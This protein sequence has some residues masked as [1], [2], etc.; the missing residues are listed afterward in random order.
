MDKDS[1]RSLVK[2]AVSFSILQ[3]IPSGPEALEVFRLFKISSISAC[4]MFTDDN[5]EF[6]LYAMSGN[7]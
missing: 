1:C 6:V 2:P 5:L 3:L 4:V 7:F